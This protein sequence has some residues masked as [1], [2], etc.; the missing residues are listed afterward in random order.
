MGK[1][2]ETNRASRTTDGPRSAATGHAQQRAREVGG[3]NPASAPAMVAEWR[4]T[5]G[6][7]EVASVSGLY[8]GV[9]PVEQAAVVA[10]AGRYEAAAPAGPLGGEVGAE[11]GLFHPCQ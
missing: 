1:A 2:I 5:G 9:E 11:V 8:A 6:K 7:Y 10:W 4:G 3:V